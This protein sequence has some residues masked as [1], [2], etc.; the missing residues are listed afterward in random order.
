MVCEITTW[1]RGSF[2]RESK[3]GFFDLVSR[4]SGNKCDMKFTPS[5]STEKYGRTTLIP[6]V[7]VKH[8]ELLRTQ[9]S[10]S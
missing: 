8:I 2:I 6:G 5:S 1:I 10:K 3:L 9:T 7:K 4:P